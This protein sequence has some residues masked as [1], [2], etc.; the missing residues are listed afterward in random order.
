MAL[1]MIAAPPL[2]D[3]AMGVAGLWAIEAQGFSPDGNLL[4]VKVAYSDSAYPSVATRTAF[5]TYDLK[6]G[7]YSA[8]IN[9]LIASDR[10]IE[11]SDA[12]ISSFEGQTELIASYRDTGAS[13]LNLNKLALFRN[14]VL[15]QSDLVA[16][17]SGNQADAMI[18]AIRISANGRFVAIETAASN[19]TADLDTNGCKDIYV[20]DL[21]LNTSRRISSINGAESGSDSTLGDV[22]VAADGSLWVSFQSAQIFTGQ[23]ADGVD[24][25]FVWRLP[26]SGFAGTAAGTIELASRTTAGAAGGSNPLLNLGGVLFTS[27]SGSYSASDQNNANDVWQF[28]GGVPV[29]VSAAARGTLAE[30]SNLASTSDGGRYVAVVTASPEIAGGTGVDQLVV[31]DTQSHGSVVVSRSA[32]GALADDAVITPVLSANGT[33]VA[34]SSQA[35]NLGDGSNDGQMHLYVAD[36]ENTADLTQNGKTAVLAAYDWKSHTLLDGVAIVGAN[37]TLLTDTSGAG[38]LTEIPTTSLSLTAGRTVTEPQASATSSAVNL[39]DAIAILKMI[40]GLPVNGANQPVSPYQTLAA[41]FDG[42]GTV[43]L[44]DAIGVLKHVVGLSAPEPTW[45][46][47]DE[48]D[49]SVPNKTTLNPGAPQTTVT[50]DLSGTSPVH[51]G[52]VGY[53]SGDVDGSYAGVTGT[54]DLDVTQPTYIAKLVASHPGLTAAQ[55]G[56]YV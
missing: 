48:V 37:Q 28:G 15:L 50:A 6:L 30:Q 31:V 2:G 27:D 23:D 26:S 56:V 19:L 9:N 55:F 42:N 11:V 13:A 21:V 34:F 7:Q 8:S 22:M 38:S 25:V 40:V 14:G 51:V 5:W 12:L 44:T 54:L 17:V 45:H 35:S 46:F 53:L 32:S 29:L 41:D 52:L 18:D 33:V 3:V 24:D 10:P 20:L 49:L 1:T 43:G 16:Q 4:L 39:Q 36:L 47:A